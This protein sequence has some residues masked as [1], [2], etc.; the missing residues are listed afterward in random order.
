[1]FKEIKNEFSKRELEYENRKEKA[2]V[3]FEELFN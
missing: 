1:M 3:S 2:E